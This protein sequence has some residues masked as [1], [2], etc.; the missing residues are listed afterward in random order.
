MDYELTNTVLEF[1]DWGQINTL[2]DKLIKF[3]VGDV[4]LKVA[5]QKHITGLNK[6]QETESTRNQIENIIRKILGSHT[7]KPKILQMQNGI[8]GEY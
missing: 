6:K 2:C 8:K 3:Y 5:P 1:K 7:K 4:Q